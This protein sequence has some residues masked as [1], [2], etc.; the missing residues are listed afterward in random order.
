MYFIIANL[1]ILIPI[2]LIMYVGIICLVFEIHALEKP[3]SLMI[4]FTNSGLK[5][6]NN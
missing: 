3:L 4:Q 2:T 1:F 5:I 6:I